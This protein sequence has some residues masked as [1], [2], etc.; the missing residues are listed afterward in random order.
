MHPIFFQAGPITVYSYGVFVALAALAAFWYVRLKKPQAADLLFL[1]FISGILGARIFYVVQHWDDYWSQPF[2]FFWLW[3]GGLVW[4]G[5]FIGALAAGILYARAH[6]QSAWSWADFFAPILP[7]SQAIGRVG[8]FLNGC[9]FG[10][11]RADGVARHPAQLYEM[12]LLLLLGLFLFFMASR[13]HKEGMIFAAYLGGYGL[14][15]F[16]VEFFRGDQEILL[17]LTVPQ[18]ISLLLMAAALLLFKKCQTSK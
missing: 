17:V 15:R 5:G 11:L 8:C 7:V 6:G 16:I 10:K 1:L 4:Y 9:C 2:H 12:A 3:E 13:K 14:I 18:W